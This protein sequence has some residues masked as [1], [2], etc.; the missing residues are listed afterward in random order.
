ME[1]DSTVFDTLLKRVTEFSITYT[2]LIKLKTINKVTEVFS[3][4]F[5]D[6]IVCILFV[7]FLLF[8]NLGLALWIGDVLGKVYLG[9]LLV[10]S[11]YFVLGVVSRF[12]M[13][14][15]LKKVAANYLI[16]QFF[17]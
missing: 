11:F 4:M 12:F 8:L 5:P 13:R 16:K 9:F 10:A 6:F 3:A 1:E 17:R 2:E 7:I 15:W 14:A